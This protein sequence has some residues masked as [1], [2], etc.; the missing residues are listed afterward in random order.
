MYKLLND[1]QKSLNM[2]VLYSNNYRNEL[3]SKNEDF[4]DPIEYEIINKMDSIKDVNCK[5]EDFINIICSEG[6]EGIIKDKQETYLRFYHINSWL[7]F[8]S[9]FKNIQPNYRIYLSAT[10]GNVE[11]IKKFFY[12]DDVEFIDVET[13]FE[14]KKSEICFVHNSKKMSYDNKEEAFKHN[15]ILIDKIL[16]MH[17]NDKG[18]IFTTSYNDAKYIKEN[19]RH[20]DR[21][22]FYEAA[23]DK[24]WAI[25]AHKNSKKNRILIGPSLY[26]GLNFNDELSR[27][28]IFTK[29]PYPNLGNVY[30][31]VKMKSHKDWYNWKTS[32]TFLQGI[33]RSIRHEK[34]H[35]R[36]YI[37]DGGF[38]WFINQTRS[39]YNSIK[40][41]SRFVEISL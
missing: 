4:L 10:F 32:I 3:K 2:V 41:I 18:I 12:I 35:A 8:K 28:Q 26:E 37:V 29:I 13:T 30:T 22:L 36:T 6:L 39:H 21:I 23:K 5:L 27:F 24:D 1:L 14:F 33:G 15:L 7:Y 17:S 20:S 34:D 19:S 16:D 40:F 9:F 11:L 31:S 25:E 38:N